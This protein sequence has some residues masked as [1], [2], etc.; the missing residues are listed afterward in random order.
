MSSQPYI[1]VA[2]LADAEVLV[3]LS[4]QTFRDTFGK[5]NVSENVDAYV[6]D[7]LSL[8]C[9]LD[10]L[11]DVANTFLLTFIGAAKQPVGYA[12]LR[13]ASSSSPVHVQGPDPIELQR[14][15]LTDS[16]I[17]QGL[18][19][20]LMGQCL[21]LARSSG[22]QT[23]WLGVWEHNPRAQKFYGRW[24]FEVVGEHLFQFGA[25]SQRD[26][27][28]MRPVV[29]SMEETDKIVGIIGGMGPAATIDFMSCVLDATPATIDQDH[30]RMLV[31]NNP[32]IPS[33][34]LAMRG[35]G[36]DPG[37]VISEIAVRLQTM[38]ADF[39]VMPCNLAHN[40][41]SHIEASTTIPF[42]SIIE[43]SVRAAM[44]KSQ[45]DSPVGLMT[46]PGCFQS[47]LYQKALVD[48]GRAVIITQTPTELADTMT[49]VEK[50]K[51]GDKSPPVVEGLRALANNL[52]QRGA[53]VLIVACTE[54]PLVL[55]QEMFDVPFVSPTH[56]LAK[57]T[58]EIA[59]GKAELG[60]IEKKKAAVG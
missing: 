54:L 41:Q 56:V 10:E 30:I 45:D 11:A 40:W 14:L 25:D 12:K 21:D 17:G 32:R 53:K 1:R 29:V 49:L 4:E 5:D 8:G 57:K 36:A 27:I 37:T 58:V 42:V 19:A 22:H 20:M 51:A 15:Y 26:L 9:L 39:L 2:T 6:R 44:E 38:G 28:M 46:T 7:A 52:V 59:L 23:M 13:A 60:G 35:Q 33:R 43:E 55:N 16:V 24:G 50:I 3:V 34:Q 48:A 47:G 18:G 31:E